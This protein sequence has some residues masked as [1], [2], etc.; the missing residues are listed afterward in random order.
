MPDR[1]YPLSISSSVHRSEARLLLILHPCADGLS[2]VPPSYRRTI[3]DGPSFGRFDHSGM[4][5]GAGPPD[6]SA[7]LLRINP[8]AMSAVR[9]YGSP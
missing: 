4:S 8:G 5:L 3:D 1:E 6:G 7:L 9:P 2:M